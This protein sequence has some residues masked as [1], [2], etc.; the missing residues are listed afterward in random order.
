M[1]ADYASGKRRFDSHPSF[2]EALFAANRVAKQ[3]GE[4]DA[5]AA[6]LT[7]GQASEYAV[8]EQTLKPRPN[9]LVCAN[10]SFNGSP[11]RSFV[12]LLCFEILNFDD[13]TGCRPD[14][15]YGS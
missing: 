6:S 10:V 7:S 14:L 5:I 12:S 4:K 2:D 15:H 13:M 3:L 8:A 9:R 11:W 1:A